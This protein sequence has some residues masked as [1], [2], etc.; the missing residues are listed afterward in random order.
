M[1]LVY[2]GSKSKKKC[3]SRVGGGAGGGG[4]RGDYG[5][6][7]IFTKNQVKKKS[8]LCFFGEGGGGVGL[9]AKVSDF[10]YKESKSKIKK[11]GRWRS[12]GG[13]GGGGGGGLE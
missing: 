7:K 5:K 4:G 12:G 2:K 8:Y 10:F 6:C 1:N 11:W 3:F 13:G 9:G